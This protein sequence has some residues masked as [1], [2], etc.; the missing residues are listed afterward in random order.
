[1]ANSYKDIIIT[2]NRSNTAD[3]KI[4]FRGGNTSVNTAITVQTYPTSN[5]TLSFEGTAGQLFSITNDLTGSIF[6]VND[7]SGIP[8]LEVFANGQINM[9]QYGG[10]IVIGSGVGISANNS[11][12]TSGQ[13]LVSNGSAVYWSSNPGY[14]GS[15]GATGP[16]GPTG[17]TGFTGSLGATGPTGP[18]GF[19]GSTGLTSGNQ[20]ITGIKTFSNTIIT[21]TASGFTALSG[22]IDGSAPIQVPETQTGTTDFRYIPMISGLSTSSSGYRQHTVFGSYRGQVYGGAFIGVGG[23]D[24][25]PTVQYDF[26][27]EGYATAPNSWRAPIFY[28]SNNTAYYLDPASTS[29]LNDVIITRNIA[30]PSNYYAD[31]QLEVQA[32]TGTAGIGLHRAG[33]SHCGIYHDSANQ[34]KFNFSEGTVTLNHN[35][36]VLV[37]DNNDTTY[38]RYKGSVTSE[39]WN[40]YIDGTEASYRIVLNGT[41]SNR[42]GAYEYGVLLSM[43]VANQSKLQLYAP[44]NG[45]DGNGLWVRTGWDTDYDAWNNIAISSQS[46]TNNVDLRAPIFYDSNNTVYYLDAAN[47]TT[48]LVVAGN[49]GIGTY[50]PGVKLTANGVTA[51]GVGSKLSF[52]GLDINSGVTPGYIKIR[53]T[54]PAASG[55]A[56]FTVNIKGFRYGGAEMCDLTI[57]WHW[58]IDTFWNTSV[59][60]SGSFAPT[61]RL[62]NEGGF[63]CIV[64]TAPGYWPKLY[65]ESMYSSAY[66]HDYASGWS[67]I[68]ENASGSAIVTVSYKSNFGNGFAM[69]SAGVVS[70]TNSF[71]APIF[72]DSNNTAFY[73]DAG[74]GPGT[75]LN[76]AGNIFGRDIG[77]SRGDGTGVIY[78]NGAQTRY[79]FYDGTN[80]NMPNGGLNIGGSIGSGAITSSGSITASGTGGFISATYQNNVRNPIWR[81]GNSDGYGLSYFQGTSGYGG[82]ADSIGFHFGTA[83]AAGSILNITSTG[84]RVA[85]SVVGTIFYD[86]DNTAYYTDP[87]STSVMNIIQFATNSAQIAANETSSYGSLVV[88]GS[89]TTWRGIH[90]EGGG[91]APHLM[92]DGSANGGVYYETTGRWASYYSHGNNCWGF[93]TSSTSSAYNIYCLTG[94]YSGGRVDGTI[95]Y[96]TDNTAYYVDPASTSIT[97]DM[98]ASIYYDREN[99]AFYVVPRSTSIMNDVRASIFY[100]RD[101][102]GHYCDPNAISSFTSAYFFGSIAGIS[103]S[104]SYTE[105][106]IELRERGFG[107]ALDDTRATAPRISFHWSG[108]VASQIA[109]NSSG[110]IEIIDNPGTGYESLACKSFGVG[111]AASGTAGEIRATNN[112]TAYYSD[113]RLKENIT[114]IENALEKVMAISG[115]TFNSNDTAEKYGYI[116]KKRQVGV[117]AQEVAAVLPE[118]VVPAPFDIGRNA[119]GTEYSI[120]GENYQTVQYEK[121][122]PLLIEAMKEQQTLIN[123]LQQQ[124]DNR[125]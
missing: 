21:R 95:F 75:A 38:I 107:G 90:F 104:S 55:S 5:G 82:S 74:T 116:D 11:F 52:I 100:D 101:N 12:G 123:R 40:T 114:P 27:Y 20:T 69:D 87:A 108:R 29:I 96:D 109:M 91:N 64:L 56:D 67:W 26:H 45:T 28:D 34:L 24:S 62:S 18:T 66:D 88:R 73:L 9:A 120:S 50:T 93:G 102:T 13:A 49:V 97:N 30:S 122:I 3:P 17:P 47:T 124:I 14:T 2:P 70:S 31:L 58:N 86:T 25:Y 71:Q 118:V 41:G 92:F 43:S 117:I 83:T 76:V 121:I 125:S 119:D 15:V 79:L 99:T 48:S 78:L 51:V 61:V 7:V 77:A 54:I 22:L 60:S 4:E 81:F 105:A 6:S 115:V 16:T 63:V 44:H 35:A 57:G 110:H 39:D 106:A 94:I 33:F 85:G 68:D 1:M 8:S 98:R 111:T 53:T 10:S 19:T 59:S 36:G 84:L 37:G 46:F 72:Y 23:N 80:Y 89:R 32:T 113:R 112:I 42:P 65:V 103:N